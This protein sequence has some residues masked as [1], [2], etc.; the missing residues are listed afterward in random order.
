MK[1]KVYTKIEVIILFRTVCLLGTVKEES[2]CNC[3]H[4]RTVR[5]IGMFGKYL[6]QYI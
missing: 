5:L 6:R 4:Y 2:A 1:I 3:Y